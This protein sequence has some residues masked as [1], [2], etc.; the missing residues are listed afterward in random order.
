[1]TARIPLDIRLAWRALCR[2]PVFTITAALTL[3]LGIG[4]STAVF[5]VVHTV[6]FRPLPFHDPSRL[7]R[8]WETRPAEGHRPSNVSLGN[9]RDWRERTST[10][11][12]L[13]LFSV[14]D[15]PVVLGAR[16]DSIQVRQSSVTTNFFT[17]L[18]ISPL[19]GQ[20]PG[21]S[22]FNRGEPPGSEIVLSHGLWQRAFG[23]DPSIV[24]TAIRLEGRAGGVVVGVMPA[25]LSFP[26]GTEIWEL[27]DPDRTR[28]LPRGQ[29]LYGAIGRL[30]PDSDLKRS[31][32]DME[33]VA[34]ALGREYP[35]TNAEWSVSLSL[36]QDSIVGEHRLALLTLFGAISLVTLVGCANLSNLLLARGIGRR[37]ELA[38]RTA[39]GASR[40][41]IIRLLLTETMLLSAIGGTAGWLLAEALLPVLVRLG[42][43]GVPRLVDARLSTVALAYCIGATVSAALI[44][45]LLPALRLSRTDVP[46]NI[47][48]DSPRSTA[49]GRDLRLQRVVVAGELAL[50][51]V[52][53]VGAMLLTQS[54]VRLKA[55]DL[56]FDPAH[57][58]S[59][60]A[61]FPLYRTLAPNRWQ[62]IAA[63]T[64]AILERIRAVPGV[65]DASATSDVPLSGNLLMTEVTLA[66]ETRPRQAL[67][68]RVSPGYFATMSMTLVQGR[69]FTG[70]DAS[71][72]ARLP[73]PRQTAARQGAVILNETAA[74][75]FWPSGEALGRFLSTSFD[76][77]I[78]R[79]LVVGIVRDLR[80]ATLREAPP[81][82]VYVP[83]LEDPSFAM[84]LLVR[85]AL[86][87]DRLVPMLRHE[88]RQLAP[89]LS[90]ANVRTVDDIVS[91]SMQTS[92]FGTL[93]VVAFAGTALL[94]AAVGVFGVCA[95]GAETRR[96]EIGIRM[97]L[98]ATGGD[99]RRMFLRQA[100]GPI[101]LGLLAGVAAALAAARVTS[102]LLYGVA[103]TDAVSFA[104]ATAVLVAVALIASYL[105]IRRVL[106]GEPAVA[107]RS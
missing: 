33:A 39:L 12:D 18:G 10:L 50:C 68:H 88:L 19:I 56:G 15:V 26:S 8:L 1:M 51:L 40:S 77:R 35:A 99:I 73:D 71:D 29:R 53:L 93:I 36:L 16:D 84:T 6:L 37:N 59:I 49:A 27:F 60:D 44:A 9:F 101:A 24:G 102:S 100:A 106:R 38:V 94:L 57:V 25:A 22:R 32:A 31:R 80:S 66:G 5:S 42:G 75:A 52:L 7:V 78:E 98:G 43:A 17:L 83:Y 11:A 103:P 14:S 96:R 89:D 21:G 107:L 92:R 72:L 20:P 82:E 65:R 47:A 104:G 95:F 105:P 4:G 76:P 23:A 41:R 64:T 81:A 58:I 45:G 85:T 87:A 86:P 91:D 79:R 2:S 55:I 90:L 67:Y 61:R 70:E 74:R 69:D 63:D 3:A 28:N 97:A 54:F 48:P 13:A 46:L 34:S 62:R 30:K